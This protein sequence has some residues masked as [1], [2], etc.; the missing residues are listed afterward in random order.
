V[1]FSIEAAHARQLWCPTCVPPVRLNTDAHPMRCPI[2]SA[3]VTRE[4]ALRGES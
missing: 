4:A 1:T 3:L 2:C